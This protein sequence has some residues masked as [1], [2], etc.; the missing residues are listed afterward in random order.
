[1]TQI[2][3]S[4]IRASQFRAS[5]IRA[6]EISSNHRELHG[7]IFFCDKHIGFVPFHNRCQL[8]AFHLLCLKFFCPIPQVKVTFS[9]SK[10]QTH[11]QRK[12]TQLKYLLHRMSFSNLYFPPRRVVIVKTF[13]HQGAWTAV[14]V[15]QG[16]MVTWTWVHPITTG[17]QCPVNSQS[18]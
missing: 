9:A 7:A 6:T 13:S 3:A 8:F 1:M 2:R 5:Q 12:K 10:S 11:F 15:T 18:G 4:Q 14:R 16:V 17:H